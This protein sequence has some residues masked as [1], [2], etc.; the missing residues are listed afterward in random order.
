MATKKTDTK[1]KTAGDKTAKSTRGGAATKGAATGGGGRRGGT[2]AAAVKAEPKKV[3]G[4]TVE[5]ASRHPRARLVGQHG[6]KEALASSLAAS[7][8]RPDE[9]T[10]QLAATLKTASNKQLLRLQKVTAF[11]KEKWGNREGVIN[12]I[13]TAANKGKDKDY[14][15]KLGTYSLPQLVDLAKAATRNARA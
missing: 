14:V 1:S 7:L 12:A 10:G 5:T 15:A 4:A 2:K 3:K 8:A 11:V 9:D 13:A 6:S